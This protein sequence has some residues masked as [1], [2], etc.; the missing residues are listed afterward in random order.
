MSARGQGLQGRKVL[1]KLIDGSK[2]VDVFKDNTSRH[3][4]LAEHGRVRRDQIK[5]ITPWIDPQYVWA[6]PS[7]GHKIDADQAKAFPN[8]CPMEDWMPGTFVEGLGGSGAQYSVC[9]RV[10]DKDGACEVHGKV[11][12]TGYEHL[13]EKKDDADQPSLRKTPPRRAGGR[14]RPRRMCR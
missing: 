2:I 12:F 5:K 7:H 14:T 10:L 8:M 6:A 1:I 13:H 3:I 9:R 4:I 11:R